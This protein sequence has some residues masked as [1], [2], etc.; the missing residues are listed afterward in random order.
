MR[1]K[2][3]SNKKQRVKK[4]LKQAKGYRLSYSKLYRRAMEAVRHAGSYSF[5][6]RRARRGQ[7]REEWIKTITA[8][9]SDK[10]IS[11]SKFVNKLNSNKI[12]VDRKNL[13]EMIVN[14]PNH[15]EKLVETVK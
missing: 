2:R 3:G 5:A 8:A 11:Y 10:G 13:A 6:H 4:V 14:H 1:I 7:K 9:L 12:S 15:F